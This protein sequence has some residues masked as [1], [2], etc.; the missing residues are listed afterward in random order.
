MEFSFD[1]GDGKVVART[2]KGI[3]DR[4]RATAWHAFLAAS[5]LAHHDRYHQR[6]AAGEA[7]LEACP[8][9]LSDGQLRARFRALQGQSCADDGQID[10]DVPRTISRHIMFRR[11]YR[12]GQRLLFRVLHA[13]ALH[14]P[15][16]GY[17]QGMAALAATLL[18][19]YRE[20][21]AFLMLVRMW[22][23]RGLAALYSPDFAGLFLALA[24]LETAWLGERAV[25][26]KLVS[27]ACPSP[28]LLSCGWLLTRGSGSST[29]RRR[30]TAR[31]GT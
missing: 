16:P 10:V 15:A 13:L 1:G 25:A 12:G 14:F 22:Q 3:P 30:R 24:E 2:W 29:C 5:A 26:R 28:P 19:Y 11:R 6:D 20:E 27:T 23:L 4:W 31:A 7:A 21:D 17:V 18:T 9:C 8:R